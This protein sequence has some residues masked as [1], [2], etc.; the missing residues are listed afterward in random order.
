MLSIVI[1]VF[2]EAA[3]VRQIVER[4]LAVK[5]GRPKQVILVDDGSTDGTAG[6]LAELGRHS[7][8]TV[9]THPANR[10]KGAAV[11]TALEQVK[12][13]IVLIQDADLE[14]DPADYPRL[15]EPI[16]AGRA[17]VVFGSRFVGGQSHR[18]LYF[19]HAVGNRLL[20][21][22][23][24]IF[25]GLN[26]TDM[27]SCYKVFRRGV[28][29]KLTLV[30]NRFGFEP[31]VVAKLAK[32]RDAAGGRLRIYEVGISYAGRT[33]AEGKKIGMRDGFKAM[34]CIVRYNLFP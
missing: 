11:R 8:I 33:Y 27:E 7:D 23:S 9:L 16:D 20:T 21:L 26:M 30:E 12:G 1:P 6:V 14:Y 28:I 10:G 22:C 13:D 32:Q 29:V 3:T 17:D 31:E 2:N 19:W 15:L 4:V 5:I 34:W 18:V 25:T 24:N